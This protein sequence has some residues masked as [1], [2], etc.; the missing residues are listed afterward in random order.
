MINNPLT[1]AIKSGFFWKKSAI[2]GM[3]LNTNSCKPNTITTPRI[4]PHSYLDPPMIIAPKILSEV[5]SVR[6]VVSDVL[7]EPVT[8]A[9]YNKPPIAA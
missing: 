6:S 3:L 2:P 8:H 7:S 1:I 5:E 9:K 4:V